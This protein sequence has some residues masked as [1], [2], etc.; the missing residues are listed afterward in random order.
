[1]ARLRMKKLSPE[2]R[3]R[4]AHLAGEAA[5]KVHRAKAAARREAQAADDAEGAGA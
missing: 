4:I 5:G 1:M 2:E 3:S